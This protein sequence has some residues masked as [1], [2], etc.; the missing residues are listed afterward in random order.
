[1]VKKIIKMPD[2][3]EGVAEAEIVEWHVKAGDV[4]AEDQL[5][6]AVM[7]DKATVEV[8]SPVAGT[9][10]QIG[11][12]A[13]TVMAVGAMLVEIEV[14]GAGADDAPPPPPVQAAPPVPVK[15]VMPEKPVFSAVQPSS[16]IAHDKPLASPAVRALA[17]ELGVDLTQVHGSGPAGRIT[18]DDLD[19]FTASGGSAHS[20][21]YQRR[22]GTEQIKITGLRRKIAERMAKS[23]REVAHF[24]YV[25]EV[26]VTDLE[27]L[28]STLNASLAERRGKLTVLPFILRALVVALRDFPQMN[29]LYDEEAQ[30]LTRHQAAHIGMATQTPSGLMVPVLHH[31]EA[32]DLWAMAAEITRLAGAAREGVAKREELSGSTI[33]VTSLGD[34]GGLVT[35]PVINQPEVAIIGINRIAIR[36]QW[37]DNQFV[38]RK[39]MNLS[40]SFDHRMVDGYEAAAFIRRIRQLL[41]VPATLFIEV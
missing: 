8:P 13:G 4:I 31:A 25:E 17:R 39:M 35:T 36:P 26:D 11:A 30:V 37:Q 15:P 6:A 40:S 19:H 7:T 29:A 20:S 18:R 34:L 5:L 28:R 9:V 32:M 12:E 1:M 27:I 22:D 2:I 14:E 23:S 3:G 24:S 16:T 10:L 33:T 38:P 41:E 21:A